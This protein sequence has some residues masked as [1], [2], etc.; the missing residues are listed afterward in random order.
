MSRTPGPADESAGLFRR[1]AALAYDAVLI[2][3]LLFPLTGLLLIFRD[4]EAFPPGDPL[5]LSLIALSA[6][7]FHLGFWVLAGQTPGMRTWRIRL[8]QRNGQKLGSLAA[9]RYLLLAVSLTLCLG[10]GWWWILYSSERCSLQERLCGT[11]VR[12]VPKSL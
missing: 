6:L 3:G 10:L 12:R 8:E 4:G 5:Y 11:R 9:L 7:G 1:C 2:I